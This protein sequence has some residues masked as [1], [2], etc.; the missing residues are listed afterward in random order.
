LGQPGTNVLIGGPFDIGDRSGAR[1]FAG[2]WFSNDRLVGMDGGLF[3]LGRSSLSLSDSSQGIP[4]LARPFFNVN[5][6]AQAAET[7]AFPGLRSG[8]LDASLT[9][10]FWGAEANLRAA[11][12]RGESMQLTL[13]GGFRY[14]EL[15]EAL[16]ADEG[17]TIFVPSTGRFFGVSTSDEFKTRNYF[18]GGQLGAQMT[19]VWGRLFAD[20][21]GKIALGSTHEVA[22]INGVGTIQT[23]TGREFSVPFGALALPSNIGW[24]DRDIFTV[25][26]EVGVNLGYQITTHLRATIGYTFLYASRAVRPGDL[27]DLGINP[28][29]V[30]AA[31]VRGVQVGPDR[32]AFPG[33]DSDFWAQGL[34]FGLE[35]RY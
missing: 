33:K 35:F 19:F 28:T 3:F 5:T 8:S 13:L 34:N 31:L 23:Q 22:I 20:V 21:S 12:W 27:I 6:N 24:W 4:V 2:Y 18:Y 16:F 7:I 11:L 15:N 10:R 32:P 30:R 14:L 17:G 29:Q 25:V 9:N 1:F 26:P